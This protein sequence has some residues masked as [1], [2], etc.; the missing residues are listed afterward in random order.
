M[1]SMLYRAIEETVTHAPYEWTGGRTLQEVD[2]LRHTERKRL[3]Y[4]A[5]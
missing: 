1:N 2:G 3:F 4:L 5:A